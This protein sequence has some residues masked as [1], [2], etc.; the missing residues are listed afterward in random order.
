MRMRA[1]PHRVDFGDGFVFDPRVENV[2]GEDIAFGE[3]LV[4]FL[5]AVQC[6]FQ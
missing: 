6:L 2:L 5:Q 4:V 3:K 1:Q